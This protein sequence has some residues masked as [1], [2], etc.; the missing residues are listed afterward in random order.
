[1]HTLFNRQH[2]RIAAELV[3]L[4]PSWTDEIVYQEARRIVIA[5]FQH[6]TFKEWLPMVVGNSTLNPLSTDAYY[7]GYDQNV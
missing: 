1:M 6:I 3:E 5:Q 7:T 2:N 4:N